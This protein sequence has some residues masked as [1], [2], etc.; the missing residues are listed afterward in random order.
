[1][2]AQTQTKDLLPCCCCCGT[3]WAGRVDSTL[4]IHTYAHSPNE[5]GRNCLIAAS[6]SSSATTTCAK[7]RDI[8]TCRNLGETQ[9]HRVFC[10]CVGHCTCCACMLLGSC[11]LGCATARLQDACFTHTLTG[12][13][14]SSPSP[15]RCLLP[16]GLHTH[17]H[18]CTHIEPGVRN[19]RRVKGAS[20][21]LLL[22]ACASVDTHPPLKHPSILF[23]CCA[24]SAF[25]LR[26]YTCACRD[27]YGAA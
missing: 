13:S 21:Q 20:A 5:T 7:G 26:L 12:P 16:C 11:A 2:S 10:G 17:A 25:Q 4:D 14:S 24:G 27:E 15:A 6:P 9:L 8:H 19:K 18:T 3:T 1:M 22:F 23:L